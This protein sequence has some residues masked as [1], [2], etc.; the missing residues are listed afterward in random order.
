MEKVKNIINKEF[1]SD[2]VYNEKYLKSEIKYYYVKIKKEV[3]S[4]KKVLNV[5][6]YQ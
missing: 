1:D 2:P 4:Q 3:L 5:F 6:A